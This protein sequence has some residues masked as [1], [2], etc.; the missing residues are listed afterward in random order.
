LLGIE[1]VDGTPLVDLGADQICPREVPL[2][3]PEIL[4]LWYFLL[5]QSPEPA[6]V[7]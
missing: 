4:T 7:S 2:G 5:G 1:R 6:A 3:Q